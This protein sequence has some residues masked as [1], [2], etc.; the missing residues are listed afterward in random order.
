MNNAG[1]GLG[2][3]VESTPDN[4][5]RELFETNTFGVIAACRAI[6]PQMRKQGQGV[7]VNVTSSVTIGVMPLVAIYA[8]SK[9]AVE[10]FTESMAYEL[11]GF[12]IKA[13]LVEPGYAPTTNFTANGSCANAGA[14]PGRLCQLRAG[15]LRQDGELSDGI[16]HGSRSRGG[17]A[18]GGNRRWRAH[19]LSGRR[20]FKD[21]R[22]IALEHVRTSVPAASARTVQTSFYMTLVGEA[23]P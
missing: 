21:A 19:P 2:S 8:A 5:V 1:I 10:G 9:F 14:D 18:C 4:T 17:R 16:L 20:E 22:R 12:S 13:R 6:I 11:E 7:I 15:L 3:V 23:A